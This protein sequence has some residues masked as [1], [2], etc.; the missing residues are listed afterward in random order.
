METDDRSLL[1]QYA[2]RHSQEAFAA[3]VGRHLNLVYSVALRTVRS[4]QVAEDV[5]QS[6][7]TDLARQAHR[8]APDIILT[9]W[10]YQVAH[11]TAIDVVR[12]ESRRQLREQVAHELTAMNATAVDWTHIEP[13][14]DEAMHALD[15]T[16]RIAVLLRYFENKSLREVGTTLGTSE[17]AAQKRVSRAV[18][19]L[20]E[21]FARR[22]VA[23]GA[24][25]LAVVI[26]ANAVQAAPAG[27][28]ATISSAAAL[29]GAT[30]AATTTATIAKAI[31]MTTL[32]KTIVT[33]AIVVT[34]GAG[35]YEANQAS[36][37]RRE[38]DSLQQQQASLT[39]QLQQLQRERDDAS[40]R[41]PLSTDENVALKSD[42]A[43][44]LKFRA[45][46]AAAQND[47]TQSAAKSWLD[48]VAQLKQRLEQTPGAKIPELQ[49]VTEQD[50]LN[51]T[52]GELK[53]DVDFRRA[54]SAIRAAGESKVASMV[55]KAVTG[56][57]Q[58]SNGQFPTELDQLQPYFDS[59]VDEAVL[60]RWAI[61]PAST[62]KSFVMYGANVLITQKAPVDDVF[63][64][65]FVV[66][67]QGMGSSDFLSGETSETMRPVWAAYKAAHNGQMP[68][69]TSQLE[70]YI[71]TPEQR[72]AID[73]LMLCESNSK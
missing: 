48:R 34:A 16:D 44:L 5:A 8:L 35:I 69:D 12:H 46:L 15:D 68:T 39:S 26:S 27:L 66:S 1:R 71:T 19:R 31:A 55:S 9:A 54:L 45:E 51:A 62:V 70:P 20:R 21:F 32:Q 10:L 37:L 65:C 14:L 29:A 4:P 24:G 2:E 67:S 73:K 30:V 6:V 49:F 28:A 17:D 23:V 13:L 50:W 42:S 72:T 18:E 7:F 56:Y 3:L 52:K 11:R 22:G 38:A 61:V 25:G 59:P 64:A 63:D 58:S 47:L 57:M 40:N 41:L 43:E 53:T 60:Q 33:A 36:T